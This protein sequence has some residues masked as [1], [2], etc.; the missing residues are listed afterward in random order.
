MGQRQ[1]LLRIMLWSLALSAVAGVAA[2]LLGG[3]DVIWRVAGTG[4][5][6]AVAS[7]LLMAAS[8]LVD[9]EITRPAGLLAMAATVAEF[10]LGLTLIWEFAPWNGAYFNW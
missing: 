3:Q 5:A 4:A 1:L 8:R 9:R 7:G 6:A 2:V 10:L